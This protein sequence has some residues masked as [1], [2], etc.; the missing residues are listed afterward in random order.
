MANTAQPKPRRGIMIIEMDMVGKQ[1]TQRVDKI[2]EKND[3]R[4]KYHPYGVSV[5]HYDL[6]YNPII[7]RGI[8]NKIHPL[9]E[10]TL[11]NFITNNYN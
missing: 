7:P 1:K 2:I 11:V 10:N 8:E 3:E 5:P 6:C 9:V 4:L